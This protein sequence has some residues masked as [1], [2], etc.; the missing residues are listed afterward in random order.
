MSSITRSIAE[1]TQDSRCSF[2]SMLQKARNSGISDRSLFQH[3][4]PGEESSRRHKLHVIS[5]RKYQSEVDHNLESYN[6]NRLGRPEF[7]ATH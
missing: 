4:N 1:K 3:I 5:G 2:L 6:D 7:V